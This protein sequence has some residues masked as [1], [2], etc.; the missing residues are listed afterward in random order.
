MMVM[1]NLKERSPQFIHRR[2]ARSDHLSMYRIRSFKVFEGELHQ[3]TLF[4][5]ARI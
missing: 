2:F 1:S 4:A 3:I 5:D